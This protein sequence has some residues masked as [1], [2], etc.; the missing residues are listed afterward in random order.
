MAKIYAPNKDYNGVSASVAFAR[1]VG[2]TNSPHLINWFKEHGYTVEYDIP[3]IPALAQGAIINS[4]TM[5]T[6]GDVIKEHI[7]PLSHLN[8]EQLKA[9]AVEHNIDIGKSTSTD[10]ILKKITDAEKEVENLDGEDGEQE[11]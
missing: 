5:I 3:V 8:A 11:V 2:E 10:G 4:P 6:T 7:L 9:Y 1:G